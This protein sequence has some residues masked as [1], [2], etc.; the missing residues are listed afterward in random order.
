MQQP[1]LQLDQFPLQS[2]Q[3]LEIDAPVQLLP[4]GMIGRL[5]QQFGQSIVVDLHLQ[6]FVCGS[7]DVADV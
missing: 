6:L 1:V 2:E 3:F 4:L 5:R 7:P